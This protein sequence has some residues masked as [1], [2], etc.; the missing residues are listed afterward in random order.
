MS[1]LLPTKSFDFPVPDFGNGIETF[2]K[3]V[4]KF[5]TGNLFSEICSRK[6][7]KTHSKMNFSRPVSFRRKIREI[8]E[9]KENMKFRN[10]RKFKK[11]LIIKKILDG[12]LF[13]IQLG[14]FSFFCHFSCFSDILLNVGQAFIPSQAP[15]FK[16][17]ILNSTFLLYTRLV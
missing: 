14:L 7:G 2:F 6:F 1:S 17:D 10:F 4:S 3:K 15:L 13:Y 9:I 11:G 16:L 5:E 8:R 12:L